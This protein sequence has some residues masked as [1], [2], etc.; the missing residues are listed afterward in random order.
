M[1]RN[2]G[3]DRGGESLLKLKTLDREEGLCEGSCECAENGVSVAL[4]GVR[5]DCEPL[6]DSGDEGACCVCLSASRLGEET[7]GGAG[8]GGRLS[9]D[10]TDSFL[11]YE[12][13]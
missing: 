12:E 4:A 3:G 1:R 9:I 2:D 8:M 6:R 13:E 7:A 11:L 10:E 5:G